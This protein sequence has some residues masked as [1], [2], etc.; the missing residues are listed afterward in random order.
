MKNLVPLV[1][2]VM[3]IVA[4]GQQ[5]QNAPNIPQDVNTST[6]KS[7]HKPQPTSNDGI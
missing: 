2:G 1:L 3:L 5:D 6:D 7:T 4:C